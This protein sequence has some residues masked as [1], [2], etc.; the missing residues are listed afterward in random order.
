MQLE[1]TIIPRM[2]TQNPSMHVARIARTYKNKTYV[3]HLLRRSY[4]DGH[5]VKHQTLANLSHLPLYL[6]DLIRRSLQGEQFATATDL[7]HVTHSQPHGHVEAILTAITKLALD[8][9]MAS[10]PSRQR[11]LIVALIAERLLFPCSKLATTRH[12][13]STTLAEELGITDAT[14]K[15]VYQ[16]LDWLSQRQKRIEDQ[17]AARHLKEGA[18]VL[19][20]LSSSFYEGHT[21]PLA[22]YGYERDG[23]KKLPIIV[24]GLLTDNE[25]RPVAIDVY[26]GNTVDPTT[27]PDQTDKL[28][29]RF[30]L[31]RIVLVGDRGRLTQTQIDTLRNYP[32]LGWISALRSRAIRDLVAEETIERSLFDTVNLAEITSPDFP[33]ERLIACYNPVLKEQRR[34]KRQELLAKTEEKL[35]AL[36]QEVSRRTQTPLTATEI[37]LKAGRIVHRWKMAKHFQLT[38]GENVFAWWRRQESIAE[39][40]QLDGIYVIRTSE[41]AED[42]SAAD[43]V[44]HYKRLGLVERAFRSLK[45]MDLLVRPIDHRVERRVRVH[46]FLCLL[47]YYV[48]WHLRKAWAWLLFA[49]EELEADRDQGDPVKPAQSSESAKAKKKTKGN[50]AGVEVPSF[51]TLLAELGTRCRNTCTLTAVESEAIPLLKSLIQIPSKKKPFVCWTS[52]SQNPEVCD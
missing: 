1:P 41:A 34:R 17:L 37:A 43:S 44:R 21:C 3:T 4:R 47:A 18:H 9:L 32:G 39:E 50:A 11:N 27:V 48:E 20:D 45:G 49:D 16:A 14:A 7:V 12:W 52:C 8:T 40:E 36:A 30:G 15:E 28:R 38:I 35:T 2:D 13:H 29:E 10:K 25:G 26:P 6:I 51:R 24:Y 42:L 22:Q 5:A 31:Q 23:Q 33:G 19:Y 46:I